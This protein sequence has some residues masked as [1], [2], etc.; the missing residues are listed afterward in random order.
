MTRFSAA[1]LVFALPGLGT[2]AANDLCAALMA[3]YGPGEAV[4][5]RAVLQATM[6][7]TYLADH[8][9]VTSLLVVLPEEIPGYRGPVRTVKDDAFSRFLTARYDYRPDAPP[10][11]A[12]FLGII[13]SAKNGSGFGYYRNQRQ[14]LVLLSVDLESRKRVVIEDPPVTGGRPNALRRLRNWL[15]RRL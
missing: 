7:G 15:S 6:H 8:D 5:I 9:C 3:K 11:E 13:E 1:L 4:A 10:F 2:G 14:R 12:T